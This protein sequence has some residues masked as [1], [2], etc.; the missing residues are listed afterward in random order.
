MQQ[1]EISL[2]EYDDSIDFAVLFE[3]DELVLYMV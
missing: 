3:F 1:T 2:G